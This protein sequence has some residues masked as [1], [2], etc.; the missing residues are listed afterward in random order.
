MRST[1][2]RTKKRSC[3]M[4]KPQKMGWEPKDTAKQKAAEI[5]AADEIADRLFS[6]APR[7]AGRRNLVRKP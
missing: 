2:R 1:H 3:A 6:E 5:A 4:C 7:R